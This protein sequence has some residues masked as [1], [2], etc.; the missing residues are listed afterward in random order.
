MLSG[1][2]F[3]PATSA[4]DVSGG[5]KTWKSNFSHD[6]EIARPA[7]HRLYLEDY[8]VW[9]EQTNTDRTSMYRMKYSRDKE[10]VMLFNL[11]GYVST[12]T[13]VNASVQAISDSCLEGSFQ[14][15]GRLWGGPDSVKVFFVAEFEKPFKRLDSWSPEGIVKNAGGLK[16]NYPGKARNEGMS[17][18][19]APSAGLMAYFDVKAGEPLL[20]KISISYTSLDNARANLAAESPA[21]DFDEICHESRSQ[22]N[23]WL[24]KIKVKGGTGEQK[25]KFYTDLWHTLL[26]R[27]KINDANGNYPDRTAGGSIDGKRVVNPQFKIRQLPYDK[28]GKPRFNMYNS[29][30]LWLTQWNQNTLWGLAWPGQ[31][32]DFSASMLEYAYNGGLIPR[33]PCGGAYSFIMSGCPA[34]S[35]ITS[36]YQKNLTRKW[37][38]EKAYKALL[39]NHSRGGMLGYNSENEFDFYLANGYA[40]D[41]AGL[42]VQWAFEDWALS[43]MATRMGKHKDARRLMART[44]GWR[45]CIHPE[46]HLLLPR[47]EDGNWLHTDPMTN[48]GYEEANAWQTT[49]GLSHDLDGLA[50][51]MGGR[52][53]ACRMLEYAFEKSTDENFTGSY[54][55]GYVSYGNQPGLST[56]H[57]FSHWGKPWLTQYWTRQVLEKAYGATSPFRGYGGH[58]EDQGQMSGVSALMALGLFSVTGGSEIDPYYEITSPVFDEITITLDNDYYSGKEFKIVTH[59]NSAENCYIRKATLNGQEYKSFRLPH[60]IFASGGVLELWLDSKPNTAWNDPLEM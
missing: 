4:V 36:A 19:D 52:D 37:N 30:A 47:R 12:S 11:G 28:N 51:A 15:I 3:M 54:G 32:D 25:V 1:L 26:G 39:R 31:L 53:N 50:Q 42:T 41:R 33:G 48:W 29:D 20:I 43:R 44:T 9:V 8:G 34:T 55:K 59:N 23:D 46:L 13:M 27:H 14:T 56:A 2:T 38:P 60:V 16:T 22:W 45:K 40:P 49:F 57:V 58:D 6:G 7:Y 24:G 5:E 18:Y 35:M 17:Y 10:A 21:W